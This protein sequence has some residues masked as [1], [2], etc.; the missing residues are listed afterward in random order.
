[1]IPQKKPIR[2]MIESSEGIIGEQNNLVVDERIDLSI[3]Y[4]EQGSQQQKCLL[5]LL[6]HRLR[7][8]YLS[9]YQ[10]CGW[11]FCSCR[12]SFPFFFFLCCCIHIFSNI[13]T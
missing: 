6:R 9:C 3:L 8:C 2:K 13:E 11:C 5:V 7:L 1:M 4:T 10:C 12:P